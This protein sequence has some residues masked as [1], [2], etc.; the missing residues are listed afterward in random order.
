[1]TETS[2][3][4]LTLDALP[5]WFGYANGVGHVVMSTVITQ[6]GDHVGGN[7]S[8]Q[9]ACSGSKP[10]DAERVKNGVVEK[11]QS[12][13]KCKKCE[14][15]LASDAGQTALENARNA[16][17]AEENADMIAELKAEAS[18]GWSVAMEEGPAGVA[19]AVAEIGAQDKI[20]ELVSEGVW[21][22]HAPVTQSEPAPLD[23]PRTPEVIAE[24]RA[25]R[26]TW[27]DV[28]WSEKL[29]AVLDPTTHADDETAA[30]DTDPLPWIAPA[31]GTVFRT[32]MLPNEAAIVRGKSQ[33]GAPAD[34]RMVKLPGKCAGK[35]VASRGTMSDPTGRD[36]LDESVKSPPLVIIKINGKAV[37]PAKAFVD[38][39]PSVL[40]EIGVPVRVYESK[41]ASWQRRYRRRLDAQSKIAHAA[42]AQAK[43]EKSAALK[44][45]RAITK[46]AQT[47]KD[48]K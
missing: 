33:S 47:A 1:M 12:D 17:Y 34:R 30:P 26:K 39:H 2:Y 9:P 35:V 29:A 32:G 5:A 15:W 21:E 6:G 44:I 24:E 36:H 19:V 46:A 11:F 23:T 31:P 28:R 42:D 27:D 48:G 18:E 13:R 37:G 43:A 38:S 7:P 40:E 10:M 22:L 14:A 8:M 16:A 45:A 41:S 4:A 20:A 25:T 3:V